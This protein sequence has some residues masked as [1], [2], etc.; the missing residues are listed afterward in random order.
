[1]NAMRSFCVE[2]ALAAVRHPSVLSATL[3]GSFADTDDLSAISDIDTVI[4]VDHL[5]EWIFREITKSF[6]SLAQAFCENFG[7]ELEINST[8][9]PLKFNREKTVVYHVMIYDL[10]AHI[11][12]CRRS[13]FTCY[14]WQRSGLYAGKKLSELY[15]VPCLMPGYFFNARRGVNEY[16][17]DYRRRVIS[18]RAWE[19]SDGAA[20]EIKLEKPM[21]LKDRC[22]FAWHIVRFVM[23]NFYK[24]ISGKNEILPLDEL[25]A[26]YSGYFPEAADDLVR[27]TKLLYNSKKNNNFSEEPGLDAFVEKFLTEFESG[28]SRIFPSGS[29]CLKFMRHGKTDLN[30]GNLYLGQKNNPGIKQLT[31]QKISAEKC[32]S[33]PLKRALETALAFGFPAPQTDT[34]LL[35]IDYGRADGHDYAWLRKNYPAVCAAWEKK[36]DP[37]FPDGEN[38]GAVLA[39]VK[40]F[41]AELPAADKNILVITHNVWLRCLLGFCL[42]L[43]VDQWHL[44]EIPHAQPFNF[45]RL[46][47][48]T[49]IPDLSSA[50]LENILKK[51]DEQRIIL[52]S[53]ENGREE[54]NF[55]KEV[56]LKTQNPPAALQSPGTCLIPMAGEGARFKD[57]GFTSAKPLIRAGNEPMIIKSL[58]CLPAVKKRIFCIRKESIKDDLISSLQKTAPEISIVPV[59]SLTEGQACTCLLGINEATPLEPLLIAP[60]DNGMFYNNKKYR[61]LVSDSK[62]DIVCWTFTRHRVISEK[63]SAWGYVRTDSSGRVLEVSVKK[64]FTDHPFNEHCIIGTF[65]FKSARLFRETAELLI[66][67]NIRVNNE[68]YVDSIMGLAAE[69]GYNVQIFCVDQYISWGKP[70]DLF[71]WRRWMD[72]ESC[73]HSRYTEGEKTCI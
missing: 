19:F 42:N 48:G 35:E 18:Y 33:S 17:A 15:P 27:W 12:H 56:Y 71:T 30:D 37:C 6:S 23:L 2:Q 38:T 9:G 14:D 72:L 24:M 8:F 52:L 32:Y 68:F 1:M 58:K 57:A 22:E 34:R 7:Y 40:N 36:E 69:M 20:E 10:A 21:T 65:W 31:A 53:G 60:C 67:K 73:L 47:S 13:P 51:T 44:L 59:A 64:P 41:C 16:L 54:H 5:H 29:R 62:T 63:P 46:A 11:R 45:R 3:V 66:K 70:E 25:S 61:D 26:W 43:P 39:R 50:E 49:L 55:W 28:F 4:I